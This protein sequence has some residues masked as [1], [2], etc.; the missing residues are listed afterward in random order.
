MGLFV[1]P[2]TRSK[3]RAALALPELPK[4][5]RDLLETWGC[6]EAAEMLCA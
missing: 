3:H 1:W 2:L 4:C 5:C 6:A